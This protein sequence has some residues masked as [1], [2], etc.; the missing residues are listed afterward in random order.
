MTRTDTHLFLWIDRLSAYILPLRDLPEGKSPEAA[1]LA[2]Q[3]FAGHPV[4]STRDPRAWPLPIRQAT[5]SAGS[6]G[7]WRAGSP[8]VARR[9]MGSTRA[10]APSSPAR[11]PRSSSGWRSIATRRDPGARFYPGGAAGLAWYAMGALGLAWAL[12]RT[13]SE[14]LRFRAALASIVGVLPLALALGLALRAWAP[15][16]VQATGL[17][18]RRDLLP[19]TCAVASRL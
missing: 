15:D 3:G 18:A 12:H 1:V 8:G 16:A 7:R 9:P 13:S 6:P 2:I 4:T 17:L 5:S 10:T 19:Y 11:R 14:S